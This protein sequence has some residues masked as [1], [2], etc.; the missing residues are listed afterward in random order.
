MFTGSLSEQLEL[1]QVISGTPEL[2]SKGRSVIIDR[3]QTAY[4]ADSFVSRAV[5]DGKSNLYIPFEIKVEGGAA[6]VC[7]FPISH[8]ITTNRILV[9]SREI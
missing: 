4:F 1:L 5:F 6:S 9:S 3:L 2:G 7:A 8:G